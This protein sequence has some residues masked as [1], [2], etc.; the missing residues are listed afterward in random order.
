MSAGHPSFYA[1]DRLRLGE[2]ARV[3]EREHLATCLTCAAYL[4]D[5]ATPGAA[6]PPAWLSGVG[7]PPAPKSPPP[8]STWA[9]PW[10]RPGWRLLVP[11]LVAGAAFAAAL[12]VLRPARPVDAPADGIRAKGSPAVQ[13]F[14]KRGERVFPW[15]GGAVHPGDRLRMEV[16]G[17]G[18]GFVS[19]AGRSPPEGK[20]VVLYDGAL[21][22]GAHLLPVSFRVDAEGKQEILSV[23][24]GRRPVPV[25]LHV[26]AQETETGKETDRPAGP[27]G[28]HDEGKHAGQTATWRQILV[29]DKENP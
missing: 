7:L 24:F 11:S 21:D 27:G 4:R 20:P 19:L 2:P 6:A 8:P 23:I 25:E 14:I 12:V 10:R 1:L 28:G 18:F 16:N 17:A 22:A 26:Q 29:L 13:L 9:W 3:D 15:T 5:P